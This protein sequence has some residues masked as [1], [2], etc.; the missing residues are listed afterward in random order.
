[1][2]DPTGPGGLVGQVLTLGGHVDVF[3]KRNDVVMDNDPA[4]DHSD[5]GR[6]IDGVI[7]LTNNG[8]HPFRTYDGQSASQ[9]DGYELHFYGSNSD[10]LDITFE[11][12]VLH[13][14]D[15][16]RSH[17]NNDPSVSTPKGGYFQEG[18]LLTVEVEQDGVWVAVTNLALSEALVDLEYFQTI[19]LTFDEIEG[20]AIRVIGSAGG[21]TPHTSFTEI[22]TF[23][24]V[25][26][27]ATCALLGSLGLVLLRRRRVAN[28]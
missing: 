16:M 1:M 19:E 22:E 15:I 6:L 23:G 17:V 21:L 13:E 11:K 28:R 18:E 25:P 4:N 5:Q 26:E 27:P 14:G 12:L 3:V 24:A 9:V 8:V 20:Q 10:E 7:D 2:S